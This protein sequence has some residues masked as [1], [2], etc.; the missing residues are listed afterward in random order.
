M[1]VSYSDSSELGLCEALIRNLHPDA[2]DA[3]VLDMMENRVPKET[4]ATKVSEL[5]EMDE[6]AEAWEGDEKI[7]ESDR[8]QAKAEEQQ[9]ELLGKVL[10]ARRSELHVSDTTGGRKKKAKTQR[11][12]L[13]ISP[14]MSAE[15]ARKYAPKGCYLSKDIPNQR[16]L[17]VYPSKATKSK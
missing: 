4:D 16:W 1:S 12:Q 3:A 15:A 7:L 11:V 2:T 8:K 17:G 5:L 13:K 6:V 9:V 10:R 14:D